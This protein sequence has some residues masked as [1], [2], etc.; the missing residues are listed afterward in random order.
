MI[1]IREELIKMIKGLEQFKITEKL[2]LKTYW[3][4]SKTKISETV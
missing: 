1:S 2:K 3:D 4:R